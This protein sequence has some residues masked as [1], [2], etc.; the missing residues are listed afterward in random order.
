MKKNIFVIMALVICAFTAQEIKAQ[1]SLRIV[2]HPV[3][4]LEMSEKDI[5]CERIDKDLYLF[6]PVQT[7]VI[8]SG[9][10]LRLELLN[11]DNEAKYTVTYNDQTTKRLTRA[12]PYF[13]VHIPKGTRRTSRFVLKIGNAPWAAC[14]ALKE[15]LR[16]TLEPI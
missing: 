15:S 8:P 13:I 16:F 11:P 3:V 5:H 10:V 1:V 2:L 14:G 4:G 7:F 12:D 6:L 9:E